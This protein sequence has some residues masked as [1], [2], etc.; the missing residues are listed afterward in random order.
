LPGKF[1]VSVTAFVSFPTG[2]GGV[3]SGGY[4]PG[5][6]VAWSRPLPSKWT[7]AGMLSLYG[8]TQD[9][10][11]NLT[12]ESTLLRDWQLAALRDALNMLAAT[13]RNAAGHASLFNP[14]LR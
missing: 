12:G 9:H 1:D 8:P 3:S 10:S 13:F 7:T 4:D 5:L 11:H 6:Q 14:E 2:A